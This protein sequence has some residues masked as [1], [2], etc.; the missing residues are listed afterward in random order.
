MHSIALVWQDRT[1]RMLGLVIIV[2]GAMTASF[3]PYVSLLGIS[4]FGLSDGAFALLLTGSMLVA[5]ASSVIVGIVTDQYPARK[6]MAVL[7]TIAMIVGLILVSVWPNPATF[8]LT[9]VLFL[10][11][12]STILSQIFAVARLHTAKMPTQDRDGITSVIRAVFGIPFA[13]LLPL[14]GLAFNADLSLMVLYPVSLLLTVGLLVLVIWGWPSDQSAPWTEEKSGLGFF[15]SLAELLTGTISIRI[16]A[17]GAIHSGGALIG[18][19]MGL[20]LTESAGRS[21]GDTAIFFGAF[22]ALEIVVMLCVGVLLQRFRRLHI[23]SVGAVLYAAFMVLFPLLAATPWVWLLIL[24]VAV[25]GG[26]IYS[27]AISYLQD[28]LGSRAGAGASLMAL[29][30]LVSDG[31][32][33]AIFAIGA[34]L[35]GYQ[36]AAF[37]GA[38]T[39][40]VGVMVLLLL[41]DGPRR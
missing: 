22:V 4:I 39:I 7:A 9:H 27:L 19:L 2:F 17:M 13:I 6:A 38:G 5:V 18:V 32:A 14:W 16:A 8:V 41:D 25:G 31:L 40:L 23:I 20:V 36:V 1:L 21:S 10:P 37:M 28:L 35:G 34:S 30:R 24:P 29:Q 3:A 26:M 12:G 15:S 11:I 33:A